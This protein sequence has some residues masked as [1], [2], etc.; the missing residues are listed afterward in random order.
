MN[1]IRPYLF[2]F[3]ID[4]I[5]PEDHNPAVIKKMNNYTM[6]STRRL[7]FIDLHQFLAPQTSY[8]KFLI[9]QQVE[10]AKSFFCYEWFRDIEQLDNTIELPLRH[11]HFFS[12]LRQA[13]TCT[14][15]EYAEL[16]ATVARE[17]GFAICAICSFTTAR[18]MSCRFWTPPVNLSTCGAC[19]TKLTFSRGRFQHP[20]LRW[21]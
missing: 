3:L 18:K 9:S 11:P 4:R 13:Y 19:D 15:A 1:L 6:L 16:A 7:R 5:E 17:R 21:R 14:E 12:T 10:G 2:P 8:A 20:A